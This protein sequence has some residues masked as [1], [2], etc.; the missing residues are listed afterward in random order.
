[1]LSA[2]SARPVVW[3]SSGRSRR[4]DAVSYPAR[5]SWCPAVETVPK[6][7]LEPSP[8]RPHGTRPH[9]RAGWRVGD[10]WTRPRG[11]SSSTREVRRG[12]PFQ[13]DSRADGTDGLRSR[14][15]GSSRGRCDATNASASSRA[16]A[17]PHSR[18]WRP[19][20]A[21]RPACP[22][23]SERRRYA[24]R[25]ASMARAAMAASTRSATAE[26]SSSEAS[27]SKRLYASGPRSA[28]SSAIA[29]ITRM[30]RSA[31]CSRS[32]GWS[33]AAS[34]PATSPRTALR[35]AA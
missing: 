24:T 30:W 12:W 11:T 17:S 13:P 14:N 7:V 2:A 4:P 19:S 3:A 35:I 29:M 5:R 26:P 9:L 23:S 20:D 32:A 31:W 22:G 28:Q 16:E 1:M 27:G 21:T 34:A 8:P 15:H 10:Q 25:A 18:S 33:S 6:T